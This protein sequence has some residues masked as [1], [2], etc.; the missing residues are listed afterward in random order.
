[1]P[2]QELGV[3]GRASKNFA[4]IEEKIIF[5]VKIFLYF[6]F[7]RVEVFGF[8][9][10]AVLLLLRRWVWRFSVCSCGVYFQ[11][12]FNPWTH[13]ALL[14]SFVGACLMMHYIT[15]SD[16]IVAGRFADDCLANSPVL[17]TCDRRHRGEHGQKLSCL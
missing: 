4:V 17:V 15:C 10:K 13:G 6:F 12:T 9:F 5:L 14:P 1:M 16:N 11:L 2:A 8:D 7:D 3:L